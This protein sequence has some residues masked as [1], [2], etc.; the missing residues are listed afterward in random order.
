[1]LVSWLWLEMWMEH[2]TGTDHI[3]CCL[4]IYSFSN[5]NWNYF[6]N[7]KNWNYF[8]YNNNIQVYIFSFTQHLSQTR[9]TLHLYTS[10]KAMNTP[11]LGRHQIYI[12]VQ[13]HAYKQN[14]HVH[15]HTFECVVD[16]TL[17]RATHTQRPHAFFQRTKWQ[18]VH[19]L[20]V[21]Y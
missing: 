1:M 2:I 13:K 11:F 15:T 5:K 7:N 21:F 16:A 20:L 6:L 3:F 8:F 18:P 19:G 14:T 17:P 12:I 9:R 4:S 10:R